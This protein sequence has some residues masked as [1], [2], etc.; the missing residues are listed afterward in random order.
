MKTELSQRIRAGKPLKVKE[1]AKLLDISKEKLYQLVNCGTLSAYRIGSSLRLE[2][3]TTAN[4][5][6]SRCF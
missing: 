1:L 2:P 5:L 6:E 4:W 3:S